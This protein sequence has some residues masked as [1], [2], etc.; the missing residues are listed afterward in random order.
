MSISSR[1]LSHVYAI[2]AWHEEDPDKT[3]RCALFTQCVRVRV[4]VR[5]MQRG[6]KL[7]CENS[8]EGM[9]YHLHSGILG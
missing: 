8:L 5:V 2:A 1:Y 6:E 3:H 4:R 9:N 7:N